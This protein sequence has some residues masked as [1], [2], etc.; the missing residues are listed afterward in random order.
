[1]RF[2]V[3]P[4]ASAGAR[5]SN[6]DI[7]DSEGVYQAAHDAVVYRVVV[8]AF[9]AGGGDGFTAIKNAAGF[10]SDTG[11]IDSDAFRVHLQAMSWVHNPTEQRIMIVP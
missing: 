5:V 9:V 10:R 2:T 4:E 8:N 11:V 7:R 6:L 1:M 3:D